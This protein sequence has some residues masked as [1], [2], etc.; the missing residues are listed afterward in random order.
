[1]KKKRATNTSKR[2]KDIPEEPNAQEPIRLN[3]YIAQAGVCSRRE[4]DKLIA[5]GLITVNGKK[6][7]ELGYKVLPV[8]EVRYRGKILQPEKKVY[9]L[10]NKPKNFITTTE[11]PNERRTV[12]DLV[13]NATNERIYPVGRLD[14]NTTGLL[15]LTNDGE[16]AKVLT[17]PSHNVRKIY[18]VEIDKRITKEDFIKLAEGVELEEGFAAADDVA[19][20]TD[21]GRTIG[22]EM[23]I[24]WNRVVRRMFEALGYEVKNLDRV[25]FAGLDKK[26][27]PRGKWRHLTSKEIIQLKYLKK[28]KK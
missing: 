6:I 12:M 20:L 1:M 16:L 19:I 14:R 8:D 28:G 2:N 26:D 17:H 11:D 4:A 10:L 27:L 18:K 22:V 7:T 25:V 21:D 9:I 13:K 24:G 23:H 15:L 5:D 3:R